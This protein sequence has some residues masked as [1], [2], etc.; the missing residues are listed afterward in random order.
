[1]E[2]LCKICGGRHTNGMCEEA[3]QVFAV[4]DDRISEDLGGHHSVSADFD[5]FIINNSGQGDESDMVDDFFGTI[6]GIDQETFIRLAKKEN[7]W[8][9]NDSNK[10]V[11]DVLKQKGIIK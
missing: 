8:I 3:K 9:F 10:D 4:L 7:G 11:L 2:N 5:L 1:M 6:K